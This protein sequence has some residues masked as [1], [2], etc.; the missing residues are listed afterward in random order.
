MFYARVTLTHD[1]GRLYENEGWRRLIHAVVRTTSRGEL[2][3]S[4]ADVKRWIYNLSNLDTMIP[5]EKMNTV[6]SVQFSREK[7]AYNAAASIFHAVSGKSEPQLFHQWVI[8]LRA[9]CIIAPYLQTEETRTAVMDKL[10]ETTLI[11]LQ[12]VIQFTINELSC[13]PG[14]DFHEPRKGR[15]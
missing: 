14:C 1:Q 8:N 3:Q 13:N 11:S 15:I 5:N 10:R 7:I 9:L 2:Q 12:R 4:S 6:Q